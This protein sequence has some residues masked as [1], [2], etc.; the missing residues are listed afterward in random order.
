LNTNFVLGE[1]G[2][3]KSSLIPWDE[4]KACHRT[5]V[6]KKTFYFTLPAELTRSSCV[7]RDVALLTTSGAEKDFVV[8]ALD[9]STEKR[10]TARTNATS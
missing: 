4:M 3:I 1:V 7:Q 5:K 6:Q 2:Q 10:A 8:F 9:G